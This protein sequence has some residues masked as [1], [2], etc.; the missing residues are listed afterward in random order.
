[1]INKC[2]TSYF[3]DASFTPIK[4]AN[5]QQI[6]SYE[7]TKIQTDYN[8][9]IALQFGNKLRMVINRLLGLKHRI[10]QL[11]S[12]LKKQGCSEEETKAKVKSN[13]V[14]PTKR[15]NETNQWYERSKRTN[16]MNKWISRRNINTVPK[17]FL[18]QKTMKHVMDIFSAYPETYNFKKD[19]VYYDAVV[20]PEKHLVAYDSKRSKLDKT[21]IWGK[22]LN[23]S[24]KPFKGVSIVKQNFDTSKGG[25]GSIKTRL[26]DEEFKYIEQIPK[27]EL[28]ATT[29]K[30]VFIDSGRRDLLYCM[31]ENS[32]INDR[33]IYRFTRN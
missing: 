4:L 14:E 5:A 13:I 22:V 33:Q 24:S 1:M 8:N 11:T 2:K 3:R 27:D 21:Y 16:E 15:T 9:A 20:N 19:S 31:H 23:L 32:T 7:A 29:Q 25:T 28:L 10:S 26:V 6:A 12:D 17:E 30:C 18:D